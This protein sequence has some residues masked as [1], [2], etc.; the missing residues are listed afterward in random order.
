MYA[1]PG[2][3]LARIVAGFGPRRAVLRT[4]Y[5][6]NGPFSGLPWERAVDGQR[7]AELAPKVGLEPTTTRLTAAC[8]T[9]ELLWMPQG[10]LIYKR[11]PPASMVFRR[12]FIAAERSDTESNRPP[13][14]VTDTYIHSGQ[15]HR[16]ML[17]CRSNRSRRG[18]A[19]GHE[20]QRH[21]DHRQ[22]GVGPQD[23]QI[24][25]PKPGGVFKD[26]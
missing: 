14:P 7:L 4:L 26:A 23:G 24:N 2:T 21:D 19:Q 6:T 8:S 15:V 5:R 9:I 25:R 1:G 12:C 17:L 18:A 22:D 3:G 11:S 20:N 10:T 13:R 16:A